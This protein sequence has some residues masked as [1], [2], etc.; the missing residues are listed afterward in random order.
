VSGTATPAVPQKSPPA[1]PLNDGRLRS[2]VRKSPS[3][4]APVAPS[5]GASV[6]S[7]EVPVALHNPAMDKYYAPEANS[8]PPA[9]LS[10]TTTFTWPDSLV[11]V[12]QVDAQPSDLPDPAQDAASKP[13][14]LSPSPPAF[15]PQIPVSEPLFLIT[16]PLIAPAPIPA[17]SA[18]KRALSSMAMG[19]TLA[20]DLMDIEAGVPLPALES[21]IL[22]NPLLEGGDEDDAILFG[23]IK[24]LQGD[25]LIRVAGVLPEEMLPGPRPATKESAAPIPTPASAPPTQEPSYAVRSPVDTY[26]DPSLSQ[27]LAHLARLFPSVSSE[28]FTLVLDKTSGDLSAASAWM[29][30][31]ADVTKAKNVLAG[32][33]P[34]APAGEVESSVR[35]C[36]GDFLLS[37]YWLSRN[38]EHTAEWNDFKQ[39]RSKGVMDV[40][41]PAPDFLYDDPATEA[42]E[43]QW[44]QIAVSIRRHRV[45]DY[46][47][48]VPMWNA[49]ASVST[50]TREITPR[51][52]DYVCKLGARNADEAGFKRAVKTLRAQPDFGAIEAIAGPAIPCGADDPRDAASTILQVLLS[53]GYIS[54]PAAAWLAIRISGSSTMYFAMSPLFL[55][56][57]VVRRKLWNDR[58]LHL[59]AWADTNMKARDSTNSPTG[60]RISAADV[61]S[62]Y[63]SIVP[64]A[65][66]KDV[67][68]IFS[69]VTGK[70]KPVAAKRAPTRA[71]ARA[72][73]EKKKKAEAAA[74][75]LAKKGVDIEA[76]IEEELALME[77]GK[78]SEE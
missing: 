40:E 30:S 75:R 28:T 6:T 22:R 16:T 38:Y 41:S 57:P 62:A 68:P 24:P 36:K 4:P 46:P 12:H 56:F 47:E 21:P 50:A 76:Q 7:Q 45:A 27:S 58:N 51:F 15:I 5:V 29:Q 2:P 14:F 32:A 72:A 44:W 42:Y 71:Q 3:P 9:H 37:F 65:K 70:S 11:D 8:P 13:L 74:T 39:V 64:A 54:P 49:L 55:A 69:K 48:V 60:S 31:V 53:D 20:E 25:R 1:A 43:W 33:F 52:L 19:R 17:T 73:Q 77:E 10:Q 63:S 18:A 35:L 26:N 59:S 78:E 23:H 34:N 61:K 67:H 66:G